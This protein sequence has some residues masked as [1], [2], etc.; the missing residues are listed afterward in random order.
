MGCPE[1]ACPIVPKE[2]VDGEIED[3]VGK[4]WRNSG[5]RPDKEKG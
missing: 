3:P 1:N 5:K 2:I 4:G